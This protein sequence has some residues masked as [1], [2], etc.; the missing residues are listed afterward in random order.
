M[1]FAL[2]IVDHSADL[3]SVMKKIHCSDFQAF[4]RCFHFVPLASQSQDLAF[5]NDDSDADL[6][7]K[8]WTRSWSLHQELTDGSFI[9]PIL[10]YMES[11]WL[12]MECRIDV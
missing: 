4:L 3:L 11:V 6:I 5:M 10:N 8:E 12:A 7:V 1:G 2:L 9:L